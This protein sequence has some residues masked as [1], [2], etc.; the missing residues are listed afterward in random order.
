MKGF[1]GLERHSNDDMLAQEE[2]CGAIQPRRHSRCLYLYVLDLQL[3]V[4]CFSRTSEGC[5][6]MTCLPLEV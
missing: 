1:Q 3:I 2:T 4:L 6:V 5:M